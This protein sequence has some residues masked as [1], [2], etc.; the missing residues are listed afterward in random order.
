[1]VSAAVIAAAN[2]RW[3]PPTGSWNL[4]RNDLAPWTGVAIAAVWMAM[5]ALGETYDSEVV[6]AGT[7]EMRKVALS[8]FTTA[9]VTAIT[10]YLVKFPLSR[11][12]FVLTIVL[13]ILF[14]LVGRLALRGVV[15]SMRRKGHLTHRVLVAGHP[16]RIGELARVLAGDTSQ[17]YEV[18]GAL[19]RT[20][21]DTVGG[22]PV[23]GRVEDLPQVA[24][25]LNIESVIVAEGAFTTARGLR[26]AAW[27][28]ADSGIHLVVAPGLQDVAFDRLSVRPV[29]GLPLMYVAPPHRHTVTLFLK[30]MLDI[31][32]ASVAILLATPLVV[33]AALS[34]KLHDGGPVLFRQTRVGVDGKRFECLKFRTMVV[35]AEARLA[36]LMTENENDGVLFKMARDPRVTKPGV[37]LRRY[38][39]DEIPQF[40]NVLR[41]D[42]S[43]V[44]PRPPLP[45]EVA[46]YEQEALRRL[47]VHP[48][49]TGLWQVSRRSDLSWEESVRIDLYYVDNWSPVTDILI[50]LRTV[51]A[52]VT[53]KGAY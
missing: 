39:I 41:G 11:I 7:E 38:S 51:L 27:A 10:L 50:L 26:H 31:V 52:V 36:E 45:R 12:F 5:L 25:T 3:Y 14:L 40:I 1:M 44:G 2:L 43:L 15:R 21:D 20:S 22:L 23:V 30:R 24:T 18:V 53:G 32:G 13:G 48:G 17:G 16:A 35:N 4:D 29:G 8:G 6:G 42:M 37:W 47:R 19:T 33:F 49:I 46:D 34:I 9:A 28:L